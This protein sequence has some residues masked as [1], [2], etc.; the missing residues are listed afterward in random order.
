MARKTSGTNDE[1]KEGAVQAAVVGALT[2]YCRDEKKHFVFRTPYSN[3]QG[4][5]MRRY[6]A[7]IVGVLGQSLIILLELKYLNTLTGQ[8]P[9]FD[10]EQFKEI[11]KLAQLGLPI[12]YAYNNVEE[13]EYHNP[14]QDEDWPTKTLLQIS[15]SN[16]NEL[17]DEE[18]N[19]AVHPT[20]YS[21][22][23]E[24]MNSGA[25]TPQTQLFGQIVGAAL[26]PEMLRNGV[27]A[28][29]YGVKQDTLYALERDDLVQIYE[30]LDN[31]P[32]LSPK[33]ENAI[34]DILGEASTFDIFLARNSPPKKR[35]WP[36]I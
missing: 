15:R 31:N 34:K 19:V 18:P 35:K 14:M 5:E 24:A 26:K 33:H 3:Q 36:K 23:V 8:L 30:F 32:R 29:L 6:C 1:S 12:G 4:D 2:A 20:L 10:L 25:G 21:W 27:L 13:L 16:P 11:S 22:L 28:L 7:D 9:R 17:P